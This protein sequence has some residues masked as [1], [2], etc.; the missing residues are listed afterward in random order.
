[1]GEVMTLYRTVVQIEIL[2]DEPVSDDV[3]VSEIDYQGTE[4]RW[5]IKVDVTDAREVDAAEMSDLLVAQG[6]DPSFLLGDEEGDE[7]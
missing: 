7:S 1:M 5:S 6:S 4:G 3:S 2:S